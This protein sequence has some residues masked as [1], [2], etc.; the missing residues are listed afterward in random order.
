MSFRAECYDITDIPGPYTKF[1]AMGS[2][3]T[4]SPPAGVLERQPQRQQRDEPDPDL[5]G[6]GHAYSAGTGGFVCWYS[7]PSV[8]FNRYGPVASSTIGTAACMF[9]I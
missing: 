6:A 4:I 8:T 2:T 3:S 9:S 1:D 7:P 5:P